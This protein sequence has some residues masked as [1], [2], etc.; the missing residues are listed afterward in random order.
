MGW[1]E[2]SSTEGT[3]PV[4]GIRSTFVAVG[5]ETVV[6]LATPVRPGSP[7]GRDL[8]AFGDTC[9]SVAFHVADLE[10]GGPAPGCA[11]DRVVAGDQA[12][13]LADPADTFGAPFRFTTWVVP[14][15]PR[16]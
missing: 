5:A 8:A 4:A 16:R 13:I 3:W 2:P 15:D 7:A 1:A 6:E 12:T 9:H 14:G 11:R 10:A